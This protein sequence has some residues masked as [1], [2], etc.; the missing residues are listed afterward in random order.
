MV[1]SSF[2]DVFVSRSRPKYKTFAAYAQRIGLLGLAAAESAA[3]TARIASSSPIPLGTVGLGLFA[4]YQ[5][6]SG[7]LA[8]RLPGIWR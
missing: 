2:N 8:V 4:K 3:Q 7:E 5:C 1:L 6:M